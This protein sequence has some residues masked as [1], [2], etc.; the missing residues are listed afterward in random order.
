MEKRR[1]DEGMMGMKE[2]FETRDT[3]YFEWLDEYEACIEG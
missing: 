3:V 2:S 1:P